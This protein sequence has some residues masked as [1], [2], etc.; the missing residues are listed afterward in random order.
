MTAGPYSNEQDE[1]DRMQRPNPNLFYTQPTFRADSPDLDKLKGQGQ[2]D[3]TLDTPGIGLA[4]ALDY[5]RFEAFATKHERDARCGPTS[6]RDVRYHAATAKDL[7]LNRVSLE[8]IACGHDIDHPR[9]D[10][11]VTPLFDAA[12]R[13]LIGDLVEAPKHSE[14]MLASSEIMIARV[15]YSL[16]AEA[17]R[18]WIKFPV[19]AMAVF[20]QGDADIMERTVA[21]LEHR[22]EL[23][24]SPSLF[25]PKPN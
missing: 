15:R 8:M 14:G 7:K 13:R 17:A 3:W 25:D 24:A 16:K 23:T 12:F 19:S 6:H 5:Y 9:F 18:G 1:Q 22:I 2:S 10:E 4:L 11:V 21:W 20:E